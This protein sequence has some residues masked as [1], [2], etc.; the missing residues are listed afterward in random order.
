MTRY[1]SCM[2]NNSAVEILR[3]VHFYLMVRPEYSDASAI[4]RELRALAL[5]AIGRGLLV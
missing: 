2:H 1:S 3:N 5:A 4:V